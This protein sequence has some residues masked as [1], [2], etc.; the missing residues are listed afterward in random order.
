M[1]ERHAAG[2]SGVAHKRGALH[3]HQSQVRQEENTAVNARPSKRW[4]AGDGTVRME[5]APRDQKGDQAAGAERTTTTWDR[6][7]F[8]SR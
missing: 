2:S 1:A 6:T 4:R 3:D 7:C 5:V 8:L